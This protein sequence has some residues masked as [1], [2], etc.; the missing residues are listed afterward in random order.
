[1]E[2]TRPQI[3]RTSPDVPGGDSSTVGF[4]FV[5]PRSTTLSDVSADPSTGRYRGA[6]PDGTARPIDTKAELARV[7]AAKEKDAEAAKSAKDFMR[8]TADEVAA[9]RAL[10]K[11][12]K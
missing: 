10:K 4:D 2:P 12:K 7:R 8:D 9:M 1:M 3:P 11:R 6:N 5:K